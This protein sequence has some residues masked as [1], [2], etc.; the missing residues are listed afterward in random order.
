MNYLFAYSVSELSA[1]KMCPYLIYGPTDKNS[2]SGL[3][4]FKKHVGC[5]SLPVVLR[6]TRDDLTN[7]KF[8]IKHY[9]LHGDSTLNFIKEYIYGK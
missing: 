6:G 2:K 3:N 8:F 5:E 1:I 7:L 9:Q 4:S